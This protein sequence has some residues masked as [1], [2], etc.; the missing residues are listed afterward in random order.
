[1]WM[2]YKNKSKVQNSV[3]DYTV[4]MYMDENLGL[5]VKD[6]KDIFVQY[7]VILYNIIFKL[8]HILVKQSGIQG[9]LASTPLFLLPCILHFPFGTPKGFHGAQFE[10]H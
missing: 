9:L 10:K 6:W 1:M 2:L 7:S 5:G 3:L 8:E 4:C